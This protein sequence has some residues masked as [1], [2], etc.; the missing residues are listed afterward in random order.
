MRWAANGHI[1]WQITVSDSNG[2]T[3]I[4]STEAQGGC[5]D[6]NKF[7]KDNG[8]TPGKERI[9]AHLTTN[10]YVERDTV[11]TA[12]VGFD[13]PARSNRKSDGIGEQGKW[14]FSARAFVGENEIFPAKPWNEPGKYRYHHNTWHREPNELPY[15]DEQFFWTREPAQIPLKAGMNTIKLECPRVFDANVWIAAFIPITVTPEGSISEVQG[16][17]YE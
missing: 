3:L 12:W 13:S 11:I 10:I 8:V 9:V 6:L 5:I 1:P 7:C 4:E 14:E 2:N 15:T 17:K 16:I